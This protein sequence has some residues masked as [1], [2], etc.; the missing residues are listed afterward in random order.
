MTKLQLLQTESCYIPLEAKF[1]AE[2]KTEKHHMFKINRKKAIDEFSDSTLPQ[3]MKYK[4]TFPL[5]LK[6]ILFLK[7]EFHNLFKWVHSRDSIEWVKANT[8]VLRAIDTNKKKPNAHS[9]YSKINVKIPK[10]VISRYLHF[11]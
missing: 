11:S 10:L 5:K 3:I 6:E 1:Y 9:K 2:Q 7:T 4:Y 8:N